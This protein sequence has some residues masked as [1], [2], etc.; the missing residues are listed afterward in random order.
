MFSALERK[1]LLVLFGSGIAAYVIQN[2][3]ALT[4][5]PL[6]FTAYLMNFILAAVFFLL[7]LRLRTNH[8]EKLG[9]IFMIGSGVKFSL[10]FLIF[11]A[12]FRADGLITTEEFTVFFVP[13][14]LSTIIETA[15]IIK[16][17][18]QEQ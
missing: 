7:I 17:L 18:N 5:H 13:Y 1:S 15:S 9:F 4:G 12:H 6:L 3:L 8:A 2:L 14:A 16:A 11:N 10:Y